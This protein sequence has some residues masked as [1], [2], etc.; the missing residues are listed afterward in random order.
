MSS[1]CSACHV[2]DTIGM[3]MWTGITLF[4]FSFYLFIDRE[5]YVSNKI[6][7]IVVHAHQCNFLRK[8]TPHSSHVSLCEDFLQESSEVERCCLQ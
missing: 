1:A 7:C 4:L 8:A 3:F 5:L 2:V 6:L